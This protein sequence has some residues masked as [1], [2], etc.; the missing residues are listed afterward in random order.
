MK[1]CA[2]KVDCVQP[3]TIFAKHSILGVSHGYECV[4]DETKKK[5]LMRCYLFHQK[6]ELQS[7]RIFSTFKLSFILTLLI[8]YA[9]AFFITNS[10][11]TSMTS[12]WFTHLVEYMILTSHHL[13]VETHH[14]NFRP[15]L[16]NFFGELQE[17]QSKFCS[18]N[19]NFIAMSLRAFSRS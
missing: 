6:I 8:P 7:Q 11:H 16:S 18:I 9:E 15:T 19:F 1:F 14:N 4:S 3:L 5:Y 17:I 12:D 2:K 13:P 10:I